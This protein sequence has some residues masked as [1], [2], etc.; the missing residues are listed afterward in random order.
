MDLIPVACLDKDDLR[1]DRLA[2]AA[3]A[4]QGR[5]VLRA[6]CQGTVLLVRRAAAGGGTE[7]RVT[8]RKEGP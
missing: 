5:S 3:Q 1:I 6:G 7:L 8:I 4:E 2:R